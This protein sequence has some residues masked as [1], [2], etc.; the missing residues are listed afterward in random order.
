MCD[1]AFNAAGKFQGDYVNQKMK[2]LSEQKN[3]GKMKN[4]KDGKFILIWEIPTYYYY[5]EI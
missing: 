2:Q 3:M 1:S 4:V 5:A